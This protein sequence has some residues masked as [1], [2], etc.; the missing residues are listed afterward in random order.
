MTK[1]HTMELDKNEEPEKDKENIQN[2]A[3]RWID[4]AEEFMTETAEKI[5]ESE[6]YA[7]AGK[8]LENATLSIFRTAGRL[9]GKSELHLKNPGDKKNIK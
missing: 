4:Q 2:K 5:Q 3:E 1:N 8:T 7:K 9:W 6:T